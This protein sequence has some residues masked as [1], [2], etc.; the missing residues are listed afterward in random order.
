ML[1]DYP[2]TGAGPWRT[3]SGGNGG[4]RPPQVEVYTTQ[5]SDVTHVVVPPTV[6]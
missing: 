5:Y 4:P 2:H 1:R 3:E 6:Y